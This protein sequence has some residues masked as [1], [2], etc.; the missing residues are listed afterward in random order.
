MAMPEALK[1]YQ[2]P[3]TIQGDFNT[4]YSPE[5]KGALMPGDIGL[6]LSRLDRFEDKFDTMSIELKAGA[7]EFGG[8]E[9]VIKIQD[10]RIKSLETKIWGMVVLWGVTFLGMILKSILT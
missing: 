6:I 4:Q 3:D 8:I 7:R 10:A 2:K 5:L 1:Q 9:Q